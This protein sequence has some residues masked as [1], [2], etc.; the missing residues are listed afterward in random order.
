VGLELYFAML[1][2]HLKGIHTGLDLLLQLF[3]SYIEYGVAYHKIVGHF[4]FQRKA[5]IAETALCI[6][7]SLGIP[8]LPVETSGKAVDSNPLLIIG[9][10]NNDRDIKIFILSAV[11]NFVVLQV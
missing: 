11:K 9:F 3:T 5:V 4:V 1:L 7:F 8:R 6:A 2:I 10:C